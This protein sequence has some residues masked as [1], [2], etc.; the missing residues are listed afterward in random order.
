MLIAGAALPVCIFVRFAELLVFRFVLRETVG[1][2]GGNESE[3]R[4]K[5]IRM[6]RVLVSA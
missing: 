5:G 2:A 6:N 3:A 1:G 4:Q